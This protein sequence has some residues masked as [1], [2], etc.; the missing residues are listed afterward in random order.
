MLF[1]P[2]FDNGPGQWGYERVRDRYQEFSPAHHVSAEAPPTL[3]FLGDSDKLVPVSVLV[4]FAAKMKAVGSRC[5]SHVYPGVGHGFFN[6]DP[7]LTL[8]MI[9][10]DTFLASLG[11]I[12]GPPTLSP[13]APVAPAQG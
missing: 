13:P 2:V 8:T 6:K 7:Y 3:V 12:Q 10:A 9:E 4:G 1:N 11:W 5:D